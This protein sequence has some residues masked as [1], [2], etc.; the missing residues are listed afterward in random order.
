[1]NT[2]WSA[3]LESWLNSEHMIKSMHFALIL[4]LVKNQ[5]VLGALSV[6]VTLQ[7]ASLFFVVVVVVY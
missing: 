7:T 1:M 4:I 5:S 3:H 2:F 6:S